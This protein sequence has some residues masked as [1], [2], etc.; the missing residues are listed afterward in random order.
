MN[1]SCLNLI[2][3]IMDTV[4]ELEL[5]DETVALLEAHADYLGS[6]IEEYILH[7]LEWKFAKL[8]KIILP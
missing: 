5:D 2:I 1:L 8:P 3:R 6:S 4:V 7:Y